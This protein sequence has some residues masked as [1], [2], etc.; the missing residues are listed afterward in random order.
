MH[1]QKKTRQAPDKRR[2]FLVDDHP[3]VR[4]GLAE[5]INAEADLLVCGEAD[6]PREAVGS[7]AKSKPHIVV[8]DLFI[9]GLAGIELVKDLRVLHPRLPVL[10]LSMHD[11]SFYAERV[12]R[13]GAHGYIMKHEATEK[14]LAAI[15]KVLQ[16]GIYLNEPV[17]NR[18]LQG[19]GERFTPGKVSGVRLLSDRELE[20]FEAIGRGAGTRQIA[21]QLRLSV[22]T[23]ETHR[24]RLKKKLHISTPAE[25]V[26]SAVQWVRNEIKAR[27]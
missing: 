5:L 8:V 27:R 10:V 16:G 1:A 7:I 21:T 6:N 25:L 2:V 3:I 9:D 15:R 11:E 24:A 19:L 26:W 4:H 12:L 22:K 23:V 13:A 14:L 20:V 18:L 17:A